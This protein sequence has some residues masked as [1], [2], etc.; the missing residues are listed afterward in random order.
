MSEAKLKV[1]LINK[2]QVKDLFK[3]WGEFACLCYD[4]D[5][6]YAERVGKSCFKTG[7]YSGS[8][9]VSFIFEVEGISRACSHQ[10]VRHSVGVTINQRSQRYCDEGN[11]D[12]IIPPSI[13]RNEKALEIFYS[14]ME[15][16]KLNYNLLKETLSD[17]LQG[18]ELNQD[19]RSILPNAC[20]TKLTI[21][22]TLEALIHFMNERLCTAAQLEIRN[23]AKAMKKEVISVLPELEE[24]LNPK[25]VYLGFCPESEKR[26]CGRYKTRK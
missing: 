13:K 19:I 20:E 2:D 24:K 5:K 9:A 14:C 6:K 21:G 18:E 1:R 22:F 26:C 25:C 11:F 15:D 23:L 10:L 17:D 16:I 7:H 12:F 8:R 3:T 4:T